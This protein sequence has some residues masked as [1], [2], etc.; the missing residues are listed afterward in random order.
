MQERPGPKHEKTLNKNPSNENMEDV[1]IYAAIIGSIIMVFAMIFVILRTI[2][3][4]IKNQAKE[5]RRRRYF[6][7]TPESRRRKEKQREA[8][9]HAKEYMKLVEKQKRQERR[10]ANHSGYP[11]NWDE[12]SQNVRRRDGNT[13]GNCGNTTN[14]HVHHIVPL[15]KGGTNNLSNLR[16]LCSSC[17]KKLHPHMRG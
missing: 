15:S 4:W 7:E 6:P 10:L 9:K 17:H 1:Q 14:L 16:T 12:I 8:A 2:Y 11:E 5:N 3:G 13:C